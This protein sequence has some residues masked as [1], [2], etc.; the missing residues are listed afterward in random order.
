MGFDVARFSLYSLPS[1]SRPEVGI[2]APLCLPK[3]GLYFTP[4]SHNDTYPA[5]DSA[6]KSNHKGTS[7][8][9]TGASRG[10]GPAIA[11]SFA[12][13]GAESIAIGARSDLSAVEE[14]ILE[15]AAT[16]GHKAPNILKLSLDIT[17]QSGVDMAAREIEKSF[18]K[19]DILINNAGMYFPISQTERMMF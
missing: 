10:I 17:D 3:P 12:K 5:I 16:A 15:A 4:T 11:V 9:I 7:V 13:A 18:R 2:F 6:T 1:H 14:K 19:L 8:F